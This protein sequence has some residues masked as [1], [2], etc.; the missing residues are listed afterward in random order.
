MLDLIVAGYDAIVILLTTAATW[1]P[2]EQRDER[3]VQGRPCIY[4]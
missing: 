2:L 4:S 1:V 3:M